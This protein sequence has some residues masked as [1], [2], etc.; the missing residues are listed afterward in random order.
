MILLV[1]FG[2][3]RVEL[4]GLHVRV[5]LK[6]LQQLRALLR[7]SSRVDRDFHEA[8]YP[9]WCAGHVTKRFDAFLHIVSVKG[10]ENVTPPRFSGLARIHRA[11]SMSATV[12][13]AKH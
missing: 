5:T 10:D 9:L 11:T 8:Q 3:T 4:G 7:A 12:R 1:S 13:A 2:S 6:P